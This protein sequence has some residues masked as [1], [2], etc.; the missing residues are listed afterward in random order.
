[1][2]SIP[3]PSYYQS[4][5]SRNNASSYSTQTHSIHPSKLREVQ[6]KKMAYTQ[7]YQLAQRARVKLQ[8][9]AS[10]HDHDLRFLVGHANLLDNLMI[11]LAAA[12]REQESWF[13]DAVRGN[14]MSE[15]DEEEEEEEEQVQQESRDWPQQGQDW[16]ATDYYSDS[17][18]SEEEEDS[19][20]ECD[21][22]EEMANY[23]IPRITRRHAQPSFYSTVIGVSEVD[24]YDDDFEVE[25]DEEV[26]VDAD[27]LYPLQRAPSH[28][29]PPM[30]VADLSEDEEEEATPPSPPQLSLPFTLKAKEGIVTTS[31]YDN[32]PPRSRSHHSQTSSTLLSPH[33]HQD[34]FSSRAEFLQSPHLINTY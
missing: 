1:M 22:D 7:T 17:S 13:N 6:E 19:D 15:A 8:K 3:Q 4:P 28:G 33:E 34:Y 27:G 30:L 21:S 16:L 29:S 20:S 9:E 26:D 2:T 11:A 12:E 23:S 31:F 32:H 25:E 24:E 14:M 18:E 5:L 10:R